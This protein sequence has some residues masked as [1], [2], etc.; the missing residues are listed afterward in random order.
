MDDFIDVFLNEEPIDPS[1]AQANESH[2]RV[3]ERIRQLQGVTFRAG[4]RQRQSQPCE[5]NPVGIRVVFSDALVNTDVESG[6]L[7]ENDGVGTVD[8]ARESGCKRDRSHLVGEALALAMESPA[9]KGDKE[10]EGGSLYD[11]NICLELVRDP[12]LTCCGHLFCWACFYQVEYVDSRSKECPVC[13]GEVTDANL[14]PIYGNSSGGEGE[15]DR[16]RETA[17]CL[18]LKVPP[19]PKARR[20]ERARKRD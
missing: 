20:I 19:R 3:E 1:V 9:K 16:E 5:R 8:K 10:K 15:R 13:E 7:V 14:I 2:E 18:N 17:S 12:V 4:E 6:I 11:C